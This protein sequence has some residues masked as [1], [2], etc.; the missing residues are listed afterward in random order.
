MLAGAWTAVPSAESAGVD[1]GTI[2]L[3]APEPPAE[4]VDASGARPDTDAKRGFDYDAFETRLLGLWFQ[5]KAYLAQ[6]RED[7]AGR[8]SDAIRA[9]CRSEGIGRLPGIADAL[10]LEAERFLD[11]GHYSRAGDALDLAEDLDPGRAQIRFARAALA[12]R[13]GRGFVESGGELILAARASLREGLGDFSL[14]NTFGLVVLV[15]TMA[16]VLLFSLLMLA[17]YQVAFRHEIE[18]WCSRRG[19][20]AWGP[21]CGWLALLL[22]LVVWVGAGWIALFWIA[23]LFRFM[24]R[25]ERIAAVALVLLC[26]AAAPAYRVAVGVFGMTTDP[27]V[28]TTLDAVQGP[29]HP[30]RIVR[31]GELVDAH[32]EDATLHF[33]LAALYDDGRY[34]AEAFEEYRRALEIDPDLYQA[35]INIGN[36]YHRT[37][38]YNEAIANYLEALE[39][40]PDSVLAYYNLYTAQSESFR[41]KEANES[42]ERARSLDPDRLSDLMS[43]PR[44][45]RTRAGAVDATL[46]TGSLWSAALSGGAVLGTHST[47]APA[48]PVTSTVP[49]YLFNPVTVVAF[50]ALFGGVLLTGLGRP[51]APARRCI[52]CGRAFCHRCKSDREG[53]EY[54]SQCLHLFV[55]GDG[56]APETKNRKMYE[57]ARFERRMRLGRRL[58]GLLAPGSAQIL[59]GRVLAG[60][61]LATVWFTALIAWRPIL[62]EPLRSLLGFDIRIDLLDS[63]DV[64]TVFAVDPWAF[65]GCGLAMAAWAIGNAS[66]LRRREV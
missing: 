10:L 20:A 23:I 38:R 1:T 42:L 61:V 66:L 47:G 8:Q 29:Y 11:Q 22:P 49:G 34:L 48:A 13:S 58:A 35:H 59:R 7:D 40:R 39:I 31:L 21:A 57:V 28:R 43:R 12:W 18:E 65:V 52:R 30:D 9:F 26:V 44:D 53:H 36:L 27:V 50:T 46:D 54:C 19:R 17:R 25:A 16:V 32:P 15:A 60:L 55:L 4:S 5:R 64:P 45:D 37:G 41:F 24:R 6:G 62:L 14:V 63:V 2:R 56:L 33:L 3:R 51:R